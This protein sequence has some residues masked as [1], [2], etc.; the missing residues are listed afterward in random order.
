MFADVAEFQG[1]HILA[2]IFAFVEMHGLEQ[3]IT[4]RV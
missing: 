4:A 3:R 1:I 2:K